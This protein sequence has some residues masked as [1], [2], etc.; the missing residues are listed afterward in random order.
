MY[1]VIFDSENR[2]SGFFNDAI[3]N[4]IPETAIAISEEKWQ[5]L[6]NEPDKYTLQNG[7]IIEIDI[8]EH[9]P[10]KTIDFTIFNTAMLGSEDYAL[11]LQLSSHDLAKTRLELA[12]VRLELK[13]GYTELDWQVFTNIW[14]MV[15][16]T[17]PTQEKLRINRVK[18]NAIAT[19]ANMPFEINELLQ[20]QMLNTFT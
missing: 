20:L 11:F 7:E 17:I 10:I 13:A 9:P 15:A 6:S 8:V 3:N 5:E 2:I 18:M 4:Q 16:D 14:N 1:F 19:N 12:A